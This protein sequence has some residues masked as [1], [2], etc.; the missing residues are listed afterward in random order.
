MSDD[1]RGCWRICLF[2]MLRSRRLAYVIGHG[3]VMLGFVSSKGDS[4]SSFLARGCW[5]FS[6][7]IPCHPH[8]SGI[9]ASC[10]EGL[11]FSPHFP[12]LVLYCVLLSRFVVSHI[13]S[14]VCT[15]CVTDTV[16]WKRISPWDNKIECSL[17]PRPPRHRFYR[18]YFLVESGSSENWSLKFG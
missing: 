10:M 13:L 9:K 12:V 15:V 5:V 7:S 14:V 17:P 1:V 8:P 3:G 18:D 11:S 16:L 2:Q 6:F 4:V